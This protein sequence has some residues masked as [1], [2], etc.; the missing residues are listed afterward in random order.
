MHSR[1][2]FTNVLSVMEAQERV[3]LWAI[4]SMSSLHFLKI[5]FAA[6]SKELVGAVTRPPA[7][8]SFRWISRKILSYL[9]Y[10][11]DWKLEKVDRMMI[12]GAYCIAQ[13]VVL[14]NL[15]QSY[16]ATSFPSWLSGIF[17]SVSV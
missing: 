11:P 8:P 4:E 2:S 1:N 7:W 10:I 16:V 5:V 17:C 9:Q 15:F 6:E 13:S 12:L 14:W 3:W